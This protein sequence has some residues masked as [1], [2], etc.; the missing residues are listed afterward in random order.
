MFKS[1]KLFHRAP[2]GTWVVGWTTGDIVCG[3]PQWI[4]VMGESQGITGN[5]EDHRIWVM[6]DHRGRIVED[7]REYG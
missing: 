3:E 7:H 2:R 1:Y 5:M 6:K 4:C